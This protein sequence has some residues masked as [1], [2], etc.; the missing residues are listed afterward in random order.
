MAKFW[1]ADARLSHRIA[2]PNMAVVVQVGQA[3]NQI[4]AELWRILG[5]ELPRKAGSDLG[6]LSALFEENGD[7]SH[8][9]RCVM[10]D[11]ES[12]GLGGLQEQ[13][14]VSSD[15]I[16]IDSAQAGRGNNWAYGYARDDRSEPTSVK[17][18]SLISRSL[19]RVRRSV[20]AIDAYEGCMLLHSLSGGTGSGLGTRLAEELRDLYPTHFLTSYPVAPFN[21]GE[22]GL[23]HYNSVMTVAQLQE[24]TDAV[25]IT[26][27]QEILQ[28][29]ID[30]RPRVRVRI[31]PHLHV[32]PSLVRPCVVPD[33]SPRAHV[34]EGGNPNSGGPNGWSMA[35]SG[36]SLSGSF[37]VE[38]A[39]RQDSGGGS[40]GGSAF[41]SGGQPSVSL[42]DMNR[43]LGYS[44]A[45][46]CLPIKAPGGTRP[47]SI[48]DMV[49]AVCPDP[50]VKLLELR[51]APWTAIVPTNT[52]LTWRA[53]TETL[54]STAGRYDSAGQVVTTLAGQVI[55]RGDTDAAFLREAG[56]IRG[57]LKEVYTGPS[58]QPFLWDC[59]TSSEP[60]L[61]SHHINQSLAVVAN[62]SN[63]AC[64]LNTVCEK[65]DTMLQAGAFLH[66]YEQYGV[67]GDDV[68]ESIERCR[69]VIAEYEER[70]R[71]PRPSEGSK[72]LYKV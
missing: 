22:A 20:E 39:G 49:T 43:Y 23:Q 61:P 6:E 59:V 16:V 15:N 19:E 3:G 52:T 42:G 31:S 72:Y 32:L 40:E 44:L 7:G 46:L 57:R 69:G 12:K 24:L 70:C 35:A 21:H 25:V 5:S 38:G 48:G 2:G 18:G 36:G 1:S 68:G 41:G 13:P 26:Q 45:S 60:A 30:K 64:W 28:M 27:N 67:S 14:W 29:L 37:R 8:T 54:L 34:Q 10:V 17:F 62:R 66:W 33:P 50:A 65:A 47:F 63:H 71:D 11:S 56:Q 51:T 58:W 4:G 9:A 53:L 55:A